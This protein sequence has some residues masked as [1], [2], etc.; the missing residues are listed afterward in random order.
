M[1]AYSPSWG[2]RMLGALRLS[3]RVRAAAASPSAVQRVGVDHQR[4]G[5]RGDDGPDLLGRGRRR[6]RAPARSPP[7]CTWPSPPG[8][9]PPSRSPGRCMRT[10][11]VGQARGG[12]ARRAQA[13]HAGAGRHG[14]AGAQDGR[15]LH[16][17]RAGGHA[18]GGR[19]LVDLTRPGRHEARR[20]R[21]RRAAP[22][23][24]GTRCRCR[25]PRPGRC[26]PAPSPWS[27]PGFSA[28]KVT[29]PVGPHRV[30]RRLTRVGVDA[31]GDVDGQHGAPAGGRGAS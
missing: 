22:A 24:W 11:S 8:T 27:S 26:T 2:V 7:P 31:R 20:R 16:A 25:P 21:P 4:H 17:G 5:H 15:A 6:S 23:A 14:T 19:P 13:D 3:S 18:D 29:V 12:V 1:R 30:A 9:R 10:A 28:A